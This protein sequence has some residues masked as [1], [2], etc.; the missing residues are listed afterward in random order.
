MIA[1]HIIDLL[2]YNLS[3]G[4]KANTCES[5]TVAS[6]VCLI[7]VTVSRQALASDCTNGKNEFVPLP[8]KVPEFYFSFRVR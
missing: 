8:L 4:L 6:K 7:P 1:Y 5:G 2:D 3:T